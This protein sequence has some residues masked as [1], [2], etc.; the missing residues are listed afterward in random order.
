SSLGEKTTNVKT[1]PCRRTDAKSHRSSFSASGIIYS[2]FRPIGLTFAPLISYSYLRAESQY[3]HSLYRPSSNG[4]ER[5]QTLERAQSDQPSDRHFYV[6]DL[7]VSRGFCRPV[8]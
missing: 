2:L 1:A 6:W 5:S 3:S 7:E 8:R 4:P